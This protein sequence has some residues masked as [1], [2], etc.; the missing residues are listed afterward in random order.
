MCH[1]L[2]FSCRSFLFFFGFSSNEIY[3]RTGEWTQFYSKE[4]QLIDWSTTNKRKC[5][6]Q[7]SVDAGQNEE[8]IWQEGQD[9]WFLAW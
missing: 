8:N 6:W 2:L 5:L 9:W 1:A 4:N 7:I 3:T